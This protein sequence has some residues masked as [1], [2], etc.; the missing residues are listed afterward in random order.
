MLFYILK[1]L[2]L[3]IPVLLGVLLI[4][5]IIMQIAAGDQARI[6]W[7]THAGNQSPTKAQLEEIREQLGLND[8]LPI[9]F[10]HWAGDVV[11]LRLGQTLYTKQSVVKELIDR[12]PYTL[13]LTASALLMAIVI[14]L[15][16]GILSATYKRTFIDA[17]ARLFASSGICMPQFWLGLLLIYFL[18]FKLQWLPQFGSSTPL[19]LVMPAFTL[20]V[21]P[22]ATLTR[23]IRANMLEIM[24]HDYVAT[25]YAKGLPRHRV[26]LKHIFRPA[27][28]PVVTIVGL[29]FGF[30]FGGAVVV[31]TIFSWPGVG[32]WAVDGIFHR[33]MPIIR[34][35]I[36][37][38]GVIFV[39]VNLLVDLVYMWIDPRIRE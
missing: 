28:V 3:V 1:R 5:F 22:A 17:A 36:L 39:T 32:K 7:R 6:Y 19:H 10:F 29:Q 16:L 15:P 21:G 9:Q 18:G 11:Q 35:F 24:T 31:E 14:G 30:I 13:A 27:L 26:I 12:F 25:A 23:L 4:T 34:A 20:A 38:M 8:P 2:L 37:V 33:D